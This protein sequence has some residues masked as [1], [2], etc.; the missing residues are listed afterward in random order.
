MGVT[1]DA[2]VWGRCQLNQQ[3][4]EAVCRGDHNVLWC[5]S[6]NSLK[7]LRWWVGPVRRQADP[8]AQGIPIAYIV[9]RAGR[10]RKPARE[11]RR[12]EARTGP[13][14]RQLATL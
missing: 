11:D 6:A 9:S 7:Q 5:A 8:T 12:G 1:D 10:D 14:A 2:A 4:L 13:F 3:H